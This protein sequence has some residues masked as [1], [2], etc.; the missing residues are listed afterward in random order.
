MD[1][2]RR[3]ADTWDDAAGVHSV[4]RRDG[5][6]E[7]SFQVQQP[8]K[9]QQ[10]THTH[11]HIHSTTN[12][13]AQLLPWQAEP[14]VVPQQIAV[15][16]SPHQSRHLLPRSKES[17]LSSSN[18]ERLGIPSPYL[19]LTPLIHEQ[20]HQPRNHQ[21]PQCDFLSSRCLYRPKL[22][23]PPFFLPSPRNTSH[24]KNSST[25]TRPPV[26]ALVTQSLPQ[27]PPTSPVTTTVV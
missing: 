18:L 16:V 20:H 27:L 4:L 6:E 19:K 17:N 25:H 15:W 3:P 10:L 9:P 11:L 2:R 13:S 7:R 22:H 12:Q 5:D 8:P 14:A 24:K 21:H 26:M 23:P 1:G